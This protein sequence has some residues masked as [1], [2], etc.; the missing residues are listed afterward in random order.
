[1][2]MYKHKQD[3]TFMRVTFIK[4]HVKTEKCREMEK[5]NKRIF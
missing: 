4:I 1:M 2:C 5:I 3:I